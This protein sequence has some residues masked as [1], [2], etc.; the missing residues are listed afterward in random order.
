MGKSVFVYID[1]LVVFSPSF[2]QYIKVL[3]EVFTI[4]QDNGMKL[5]LEKCHFFQEVEFL[6]HVLSTKGIQP[7][8]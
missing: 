2:E 3:A 8:S 1:D 4:L 7:I 6:D 5:N